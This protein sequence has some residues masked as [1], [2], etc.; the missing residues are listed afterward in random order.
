MKSLLL[1]LLFSLSGS[2]F[3]LQAQNLFEELLYPD[4]E[5]VIY[6]FKGKHEI[7]IGLGMPNLI[8]AGI[9]TFDAIPSEITGTFIEE[10]GSSSPQ[11]SFSY[12]YGVTETVSLGPY[13]GY[14]TASTPSFRWSSPAIDPIPF[15][16]PEGLA[17]RDGVYSY[18]IS[19]L[20]LGARAVIHKAL[21]EQFDLYGVFFYGLNKVNVTEKGGLPDEDSLIDQLGT[22]AGIGIVD[23]PVPEVSYS[24]Q[25]G[26]QYFFKDK[27]GIYAEAG[28]GVTIVNFGLAFK[29]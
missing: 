15:I 20:S 11:F 16:L 12:D 19:V 26:A 22:L 8:G 7:H 25:L 27:F 29:F 13:I 17:A 2:L 23:V 3:Q 1:L 4:P 18:D 9:A 21:S 5:S 6:S 24:A 28:F 10:D 14:C